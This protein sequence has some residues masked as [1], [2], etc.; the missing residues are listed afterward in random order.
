M[1]M[2]LIYFKKQD[3]DFDFDQD[4][5]GQTGTYYLMDGTTVIFSKTL[6]AVDESVGTYTMI[7]SEGQTNEDLKK[8]TYVVTFDVAGDVD[9]GTSFLIE[10]EEKR[11]ADI[12]NKYSLVF[13]ND[14][15]TAAFNNAIKKTIKFLYSD[16][17]DMKYNT[18]NG[19][20][21]ELLEIDNYVADNLNYGF[22]SEDNLRIYEYTNTAPYVVTE[23]NSNISSVQFDY[24]NGKTIITMDDEYP[25]DL[26]T[27]KIDYQ[28]VSDK[29]S[30]VYDTVKYVQELYTYLYLLD[31]TEINK[32]QLG[33]TIKEINGVSFTY[34][35]DSIED[36]KIK[37]RQWIDNESTEFEEILVNNVTLS[38]DY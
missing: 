4:L 28:K 18:D 37:I 35:K 32:L 1:I 22:V 7:L 21:S 5:T 33:F 38:N 31:H 25:S 30:N 12:K 8:Y 34:D 19:S 29:F 27:L 11:I 10:N 9:L 24:P 20:G 2:Y 23:L 14:A 26:N 36:L 3:V 6:T 15:M 17:K 16:G 13:D